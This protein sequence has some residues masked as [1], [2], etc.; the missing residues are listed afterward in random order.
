[1]TIQCCYIFPT[2]KRLEAQPRTRGPKAGA[3]PS[4]SASKHSQTVVSSVL[5]SNIMMLFTQYSKPW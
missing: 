5:E 1:M 4:Q 2:N 3:V